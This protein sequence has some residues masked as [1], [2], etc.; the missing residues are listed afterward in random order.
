MFSFVL[1]L[2]H[3]HQHEGFHRD[4]MCDQHNVVQKSELKG[5]FYFL[6]ENLGLHFKRFM[7]S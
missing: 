4:F 7:I 3:N 5:I 6:L 1:L 2:W